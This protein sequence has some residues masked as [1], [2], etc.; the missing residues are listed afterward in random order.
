MRKWSKE[1]DELLKQHYPHCTI[2]ELCQLLP[3][4]TEKGI[5]A[6]AY[7]LRVRKTPEYLKTMP[8]PGR[9]KKGMVPF[10]KGKKWEEY[11]SPEGAERSRKTQYKPGNKPHKILPIGT[12]VVIGDYL[13]V[14]VADTP[15]V[16]KYDNWKAKHRLLWESVNGPIPDGYNIQFKDNNPKN[17]TIDNLYMISQSEQMKVNSFMNLPDEARE[18]LK[19]VSRLTRAINKREKYEQKH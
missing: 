7:L 15:K 6:R 8:N 17:I 9:W 5:M 13:Y 10:T 4:R 1:E 3:N 19:A 16:S 12:E 14:K 2:T 18:L 11:M